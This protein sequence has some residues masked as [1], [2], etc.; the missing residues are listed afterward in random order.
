MEITDISKHFVDSAVA[1]GC[2]GEGGGTAPPN[3]FWDFL[4]YRNKWFTVGLSPKKF[5]FI[6]FNDSLSKIMKNA[7]YFILKA[8][9]VLKIF[10]FWS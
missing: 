8:L 5:A 6:S 4:F 3:N 7:F 9:F 1:T 2:G 10:K